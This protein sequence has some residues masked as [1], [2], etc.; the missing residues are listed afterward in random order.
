LA[1]MGAS[2]VLRASALHTGAIGSEDLHK[3]RDFGPSLG[4]T[5]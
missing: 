2:A 1:R 3:H 4:L 5:R